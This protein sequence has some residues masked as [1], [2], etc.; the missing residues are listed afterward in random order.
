MPA[1]GLFA[2]CAAGRAATWPGSAGTSLLQ[3]LEGHG[4]RVLSVSFS[5]DGQTLA[6]GS[7]DRTVKLWSRDGTLLQTLEG[8]SDSV[9]SVSFSPDGQTLASAS[10][11]GTVKLWPWSLSLDTLVALSCDWLHDYLRTNPNVIDEDRAL[12]GIQPM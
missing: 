8:H 4:S 3:T 2:G 10:D 6:S 12:C 11:D 7:A 1:A 5:P 9:R